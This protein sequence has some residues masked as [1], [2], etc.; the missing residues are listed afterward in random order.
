M[1]GRQVPPVV[2]RV[3]VGKG[4]LVEVQQRREE[5]HAVTAPQHH[6]IVAIAIGSC[7]DGGSCGRRGG[8]CGS[9]GGY[10]LGGGAVGAPFGSAAAAAEQ[11][12]LG[13]VSDDAP[14]GE[15][16]RREPQRLGDARIEAR[17]PPPQVRRQ[18][19]ALYLVALYLV[20]PAAA[21]CLLLLLLPPLLLFIKEGEQLPFHGALGA[22]AA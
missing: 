6:V 14:H 1:A 22:R 17:E 16:R 4:G 12:P 18:R 21:L 19:Q 15:R 9:G 2:P 10:G 20:L 3:R 13:A 8:G 11:E 5:R 7:G